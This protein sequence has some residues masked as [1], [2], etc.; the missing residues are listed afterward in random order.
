[1]NNHL[2]KAMALNGVDPSPQKEK[3][4]VT[5][6]FVTNVKPHVKDEK[7]EDFMDHMEQQ[8]VQNAVS[9]YS[10]GSASLSKEEEKTLLLTQKLFNQIAEYGIFVEAVQALQ[11]LKYLYQ[12][13]KIN[14]EVLRN[15]MFKTVENC[16]LQKQ[17]SDSSPAATPLSKSGRFV[18]NMSLPLETIFNSLPILLEQ[19]RE[20]RGSH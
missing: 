2:Q 13:D 3:F 4:Y 12:R 6:A 15:E 7:Y 1:M 11:D 17:T 16:L 9:I 20:K 19:A 10:M 14:Q 5:N 8:R 18:N